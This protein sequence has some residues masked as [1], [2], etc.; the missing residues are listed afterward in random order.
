MTDT[1][2]DGTHS[3]TTADIKEVFCSK[4]IPWGNKKT[5]T[6][7]QVEIN[8]GCYFSRANCTV[9]RSYLRDV[10]VGVGTDHISP[11]SWSLAPATVYPVLDS[12]SPLVWPGTTVA[13]IPSLP[14]SNATILRIPLLHTTPGFA[15]WAR[16]G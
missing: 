11:C 6:G 3:L 7:T 14:L 16:I 1:P 13:S 12:Q 8:E 9:L 2:Q 10:R 5:G 15:A 4:N